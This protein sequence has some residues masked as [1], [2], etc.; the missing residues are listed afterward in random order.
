MTEEEAKKTQCP[1]FVH[2]C[3]ISVWLA[4]AQAGTSKELI[5]NMWRS[6]SYCK[7]SDCQWWDW[8]ESSLSDDPEYRHGRCGV[9]K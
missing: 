3:Y 7:G 2:G 6:L 4:Q 9:I 5:K 8:D 1:I